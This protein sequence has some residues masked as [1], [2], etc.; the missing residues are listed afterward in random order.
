MDS[1]PLPMEDQTASPGSND[2]PDE[3]LPYRPNVWLLDTPMPAGTRV[4]GGAEPSILADRDGEFLWI[5]DTTG[6]YYS[7]DNGTSWNKMPNFLLPSVFVDGW[8]L[9]QDDTGALYAAALIGPDIDVS[10]STNGKTW[11]STTRA[12][13][14]SGTTDRPWLAA[15]GDGEVVLFYFD[16]PAVATGFFEHCARSTDKGATWIDRDPLAGSPQGGNAVFDDD[17]NFYYADDDGTAYRFQG[18]CLGGADVRTMFVGGLGANNMIQLATEGDALYSAAAKTD[19]TGIYLS[20]LRGFAGAP[21]S[22]TISPPVLQSN[23]FATLSVHNGQLAV[24][25]YGS[26]T[27]GDPSD[28][29]FAGAFNVYLAIVDNFWSDEP[30]IRHLR[31]TEEPNHVGDIC[32]SGIGCSTDSNADRDLLDYFM[33]DHDKWGGIHVAYGDDGSTS[34]RKVS[35]A[36][37]PPMPLEPTGSGLTE[38]GV[39]GDAP[40]VASFTIQEHETKV[41]VDASSSLD[42]EGTT[43]QYVWDWGDGTTDTGVRAFHEYASFG[44]VSINLTVV[45]EAGNSAWNL[46]RLVVG[47]DAPYEPP[48]ADWTFTP[49]DPTAG[50]PVY[51]SDLSHDSDGTIESWLW[52]FGDGSRSTESSPEHTYERP[53]TFSVRLLVTDDWRLTDQY[54]QRIVVEQ[55]VEVEPTQDLPREKSPGPGTGLLLVALGASAAF[56]AAARRRL[57]P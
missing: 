7:D 50:T 26:E 21:R 16:A 36:H 35:Y 54:V 45:D 14:V 32:M 40:P 8:A 47:D 43:L 12:A 37:V 24:A 41:K 33:V 34:T 57:T 22:L 38:P 19:N 1:T 31:L 48:M 29:D 10:R 42:P 49:S 46:Q 5:G 52:D 13:A 28:S 56:V 53:G 18:S 4:S 55:S 39:E 25:W 23:A 44:A 51:F 30:S 2:A 20:G 11:A 6:A 3:P 17:G 9:A 27:P 15:Q